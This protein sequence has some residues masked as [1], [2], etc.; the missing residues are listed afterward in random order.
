MK[1]EVKEV[2]IKKGV[3]K[4]CSLYLVS[5]NFYAEEAMKEIPKILGRNRL[6]N[7]EFGLRIKYIG[8][9]LYTVKTT[10]SID[11]DISNRRKTSTKKL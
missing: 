5:F 3:P 6:M 2:S 7:Q 8:P 10:C 11:E 4:G 9:D 1:N